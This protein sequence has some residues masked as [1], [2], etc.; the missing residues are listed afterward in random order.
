MEK[1]FQKRRVLLSLSTKFFFEELTQIE[2]SISKK[3]YS[4]RAYETKK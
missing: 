4:G 3:Q 1:G 2:W